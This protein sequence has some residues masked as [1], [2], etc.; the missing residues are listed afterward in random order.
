AAGPSSRAHLAH[1]FDPYSALGDQSSEAW[2]EAERY[3][4]L[5]G[6][7]PTMFRIATVR[8]Y[9]DEK[10]RRLADVV[11]V[12]CHE[13]SQSAASPNLWTSAAEIFTETFEGEIDSKQLMR[14]AQFFNGGHEIALQTISYIGASLECSPYQALEIHLAIMPFIQRH[15]VIFP[16]IY[17]ETVTP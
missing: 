13:L 5:I 17:R 10:A 6:L 2:Q 15:F 4:S 11:R 8:L 12:A 7:V 14:K 1:G 9:D 3:G 16:S